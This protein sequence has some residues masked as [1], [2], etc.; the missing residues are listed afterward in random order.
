MQD[1]LAKTTLEGATLAPSNHAQEAHSETDSLQL[2]AA[3]K[4][5]VADRAY[6]FMF[7]LLVLLQFGFRLALVVTLVTLHHV[8][9]LEC[10]LLVFCGTVRDD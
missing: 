1:L 3:V 10:Q 5:S 6:C 7:A 4:L 2:G 8:F 9:C